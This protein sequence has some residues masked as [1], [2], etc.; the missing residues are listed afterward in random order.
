MR[1]VKILTLLVILGFAFSCER[2]I[3]IPGQKIT[4]SGEVVTQE[5]ELSSFVSLKSM[6]G[7]NLN[8]YYS[9]ESYVRITM[10]QNLFEH[11]ETYVSSNTL[12][13]SF[14]NKQVQTSVPIVIDV[15]TDDLDK[16]ELSGAGE[17]VSELPPSSI[18]IT[19]AGN[20]KCTGARDKVSANITGYG[21][22]DLYDMPVKEAEVFI[23]GNGS[24]YLRASETIT[25]TI[26]GMGNVYYKGNPSIS[27][28]ITGM[29]RIISVPE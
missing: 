19:G 1:A 10:Q 6:I 17:I 8:I 24:V 29:G 18:K 22:I 16:L 5:R 14:N 12:F 15:Y 26:S 25:A 23:S 9:T 20:V 11:L 21:A 7:A 3:D 13:F 2:V 27:Q 28:I 4:G